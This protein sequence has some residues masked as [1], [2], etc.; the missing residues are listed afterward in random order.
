MEKAAQR[1]QGY[2]CDCGEG[3]V[4]SY[5]LCGFL[6]ISVV[7]LNI[8]YFIDLRKNGLTPKQAEDQA[9][10]DALAWWP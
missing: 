10:A 7:A 2:S 8:W 6:V 4:V 9:R 5:Y 3:I 1:D